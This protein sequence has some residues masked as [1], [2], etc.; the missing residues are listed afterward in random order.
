MNPYR[1]RT[2][3]GII[4]LAAL[5]F[6][7]EQARHTTFAMSWGAVPLLIHHAFDAVR[8]GELS[9]VA[10]RNLARLVTAIFLHG[11]FEHILF[12]MVFLW[13]FGYLASE[14]LGE[15]WALG[16]FLLTGVCGNVA[17]VCLNPDSIIPTIGA[18]GAVCGF[19]GLYLGLVLRW[20]MPWPDVW[21][22]AHPIPP[23][24]LGAFAVVGFIGDAYFLMNRAQHIA[25]GAHVG[26]F[27][28]GL[29]V[30]LVVTLVWPTRTAFDRRR[31]GT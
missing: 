2:I 1:H 24:Q 8:H 17:E 7:A 15:W 23:L 10:F 13:T 4:A 27:L 21:P 11:G 20:Q 22:L 6:L 19:E 18:S 9:L 16:V 30:A 31:Y 3:I 28:S 29:V 5:V 26:G 25:Y 14:Y 12:N